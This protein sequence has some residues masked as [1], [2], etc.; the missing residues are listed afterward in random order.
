MKKEELVKM[1]F[2]KGMLLSSEALE[3]M[4]N[5]S[6]KEAQ[7]I[8]VK[9]KD[10]VLL[11][12]QIIGIKR[13]EIVKNLTEKKIIDDMTYLNMKFE[14]IKNIIISKMDKKYV[15]IGNITPS[16]EDIYIIG[17]IKDIKEGEKTLIEI[18][19][20]TGS[21]MITF[22]EGIKADLDDVVAVQAIPSGKTTYGKKIIYPDVPLREPAKANGKA[23]FISD[24]HID[25]MPQSDIQRFFQWFNQQNI[26]Y[27][28]VAGD[29]MDISE[30][31]KHCDKLTFI[32]PGEHDSKDSY[33]QT[34]LKTTNDNIIS[35][36]NPSIVNINGVNILLI[37]EFDSAMLKKRHLGD[38]AIEN[39]YL[40]L[41]T[42]PDIVHYGHTHKPFVS[43][44]KSIT[45]VNSGSPLTEFR[46]VVIDLETREWKQVII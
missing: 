21:R 5:F 19:D 3:H 18:E 31:E 1:F 35:L 14:N 40:L 26:N 27:L 30:F 13:Y 6:D 37:H 10:I 38:A 8:L 42:V 11:K 9:N 24:L 28:F 4:Q 2:S 33:P 39:D 16:R 25:E 29:I 34:A 20:Q 23:C 44:Y 12:N 15:S 41:D 17:M 46:P 43:N 45:L 22:D 32:I 7:D 36:S